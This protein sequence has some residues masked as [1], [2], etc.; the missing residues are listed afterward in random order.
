MSLL[1]FNTLYKLGKSVSPC[2]Q[3]YPAEAVSRTQVDLQQFC[4]Q[5]C[6]ILQVVFCDAFLWSCPV[7]EWCIGQTQFFLGQDWGGLFWWVIVKKSMTHLRNGL[8]QKY[9]CTSAYTAADLCIAT[10]NLSDAHC[11][12]QWTPVASFGY[13]VQILRV[14]LGRL[15]PA[16][17]CCLPCSMGF[18][19]VNFC[20]GTTGWCVGM[21]VF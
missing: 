11:A 13:L 16:V 5:G 17:F 7:G 1:L 9:L 18:Q 8:F 3:E 21:V 4:S 14:V 19:K 12:Y 20:C 2:T 10:P 15:R 6:F